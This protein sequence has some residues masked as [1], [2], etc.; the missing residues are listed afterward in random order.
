M[1]VYAFNPCAQRQAD[2]CVF[3]V[4]LIY[5]VR[6][7]PKKGRRERRRGGDREEKKGGHRSQF[8]F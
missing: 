8:H 6:P 5:K 1:V 7:Y 3:D 4:S 2:I